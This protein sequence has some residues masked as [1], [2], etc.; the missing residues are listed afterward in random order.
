MRVLRN[1]TSE[2]VLSTFKEDAAEIAHN[3]KDNMAG[4]AIVAWGSDG[5]TSSG[6][7]VKDGRYIGWYELPEFVKSVLH[8]R[9]HGD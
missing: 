1:T 7:R 4:Y 9:V 3:R 2:V 5:G 8:G 6:L